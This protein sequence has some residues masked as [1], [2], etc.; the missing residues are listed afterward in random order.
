MKYYVY[1]YLDPR[2]PGSFDYGEFHFDHEP[3]MWVREVGV[4]VSCI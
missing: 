4:N 1:V 3:F 2:K